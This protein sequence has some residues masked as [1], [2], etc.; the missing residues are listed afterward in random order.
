VDD[1][2]AAELEGCRSHGERLPEVRFKAQAQGFTL[3]DEM[4]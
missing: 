2:A 1:F 3:Q 4:A